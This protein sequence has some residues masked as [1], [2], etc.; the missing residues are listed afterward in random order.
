MSNKALVSIMLLLSAVILRGDN[1]EWTKGA[2]PDGLTGVLK[3]NQL[4]PALVNWSAD[5][6]QRENGGTPFAVVGQFLDG[7]RAYVQYDNVGK[8]LIIGGGQHWM[9]AA[10]IWRFEAPAGK[11][12]V[13]G[14]V[15]LDGEAHI[16]G[17]I[18]TLSCA[19]V[20]ASNSLDLSTYQGAGGGYYNYNSAD[21]AKNWFGAFNTRG[22]VTVN[23]PA[24]CSTFYVVAAVDQTADW[25]ALQLYVYNLQVNAVL[26]NNYGLSI[27]T[28]RDDPLWV[29]DDVDDPLEILVVSTGDS[30]LSLNPPA[31]VDWQLIRRGSSEV[32]CSGYDSFTDGSTHVDLKMASPGFYTLKVFDN[33]AM[34]NMLDQQDIVILPQQYYPAT[35][36]NSIYGFFGNGSD[37]RLCHLF[38]SR[39]SVACA[40]WAFLQPDAA[41][42]PDFAGLYDNICLNNDWGLETIIHIDT[43]PGWANGGNSSYYPPTSAFL[44][45]WQSFNNAVAT[46]LKGAAV[47]YESWNEINNPICAPFSSPYDVATQ[48]SV[49]KQLIQY[50][51][52]GLKSADWHINLAGG[53][54]AGLL[55]DWVDDLYVSP[56]SC[57]NSMD[58]VSAH[59]YCADDGSGIH[60]LPPEPNLVPA[61]TAFRESMNNSGGAAHPLFFTEFGWY[62]ASGATTLEQQARWVARQYAIVNAYREALNLKAMLHF[63]FTSEPHYSI[64]ES[65]LREAYQHRFRPVINAFSTSSSLLAGTNL[66]QAVQDYPAVVRAYKFQREDEIIYAC[67]ATESATEKT[68]TLPVDESQTMVR[69]GLMGEKSFQLVSPGMAVNLPENSDPIYLVQSQKSKIDSLRNHLVFS[70]EC[71]KN[72]DTGSL[73]LANTGCSGTLSVLGCS[74]QG[75]VS[76]PGNETIL[77]TGGGPVDLPLTF[78]TRDLNPGKYTATITLTDSNNIAPEKQVTVTLHVA[79]LNRMTLQDGDNGASSEKSIELS[80][81]TTVVWDKYDDLATAKSKFYAVDGQAANVVAW[82]PDLDRG[83]CLQLGSLSSWAN[84]SVT[85]KFTAP[86]GCRFT[87]GQ[88]QMQA[89]SYGGTP[90]SLGLYVTSGYSSNYGDFNLSQSGTLY[91]SDVHAPPAEWTWDNW[92]VNIPAGASE[93][94]V[95]IYL[96]ADYSHVSVGYLRLA[97]V[98]FGATMQQGDQG[99][100][101]GKSITLKEGNGIIWN[102]GVSAAQMMGT[103]YSAT[104]QLPDMIHWNVDQSRG[105]CIQMGSVSNWSN[106]SITHKIKA[107]DGKVFSGGRMKLTGMGYWSAPQIGLYATESFSA[108][109][110]NFDLNTCGSIY[111]SDYHAPPAAWTWD[112]WQIDI[113]VGVSE[114]YLTVQHTTDYHVVCLG[115]LTAE[116]VV[117]VKPFQYSSSGEIAGNSIQV[118]ENAIYSV[119]HNQMTE[120]QARDTIYAVSAEDGVVVDWKVE[121]SG[122]CLNFGNTNSTG[123][124]AVTWKFTAPPGKVFKSG[125]VH[126]DGY[127]FF[128]AAMVNLYLTSAY[129]SSATGDFNLSASGKLYDSDSHAT[130]AA[131]LWND[132]YVD[133]P[134]GVSEFYVTVS[135]T[136]DF[137]CFSMGQLDLRN[138]V[139]ATPLQDGK[140]GKILGHTVEANTGT[141]CLFNSAMTVEEVKSK[142]YAVLGQEENAVRWQVNAPGDCIS[143]GSATSRANGSIVLKVKAPQGKKFVG[144]YVDLSGMTYF[145]GAP[146]NLYVSTAFAA[147]TSGAVDLTG[148]GVINMDDHSTI[149]QWQWSNWQVNVPPDVSEFYIIVD[150]DAD[151]AGSCLRE[152]TLRDIITADQ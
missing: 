66:L 32:E 45:S 138:I 17:G 112:T 110:G 35:S 41:L 30:A 57:S 52:N 23:I 116:D 127:T 106:A 97:E 7:Y 91:G 93:F 122:T 51:Y 152:L 131:Y 141:T 85:H 37:R 128:G 46:E 31:A 56:Y 145:V 26:D 1:W 2:W 102:T 108:N 58:L 68:V 60:K 100:V 129:A 139:C 50:Q 132:W 39:W 25:T 65:G 134:D 123:N 137:S 83:D 19:Y 136:Q 73:T 94:Y 151:F 95:T 120:T 144:G 135:H 77:A 87:G 34:T 81:G 124:S 78:A 104:A 82:N 103:L 44:G 10:V 20:G 4:K 48:L 111:D 89:L 143:M 88:I 59:P 99:S 33:P 142:F 146:I 6:T 49:G 24:N 149:G 92:V 119:L 28:N 8:K 98:S 63:T 150:H 75:W 84:A 11:T 69:I 54:F 72:L 96:P 5:F 90:P 15:T 27:V 114:F 115:A 29:A 16:A 42:P 79:D 43:A 74:D 71:G 125:Q 121:S 64:F 148:C 62:V 70:V 133:V 18:P 12:F 126:V 117:F 47:W 113:P 9:N 40:Q 105:D 76:C 13:G 61:L 130:E 14:T 55:A 22:T 101:I 118:V 36:A 147:T 140:F 21:F 107:P 53:C 38:G 86:E 67:W 109:Y 3:K 80:E